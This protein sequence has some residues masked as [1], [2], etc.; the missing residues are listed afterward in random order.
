M[1]EP[2]LRARSSGDSRGKT[3]EFAHDWHQLVAVT[4]GLVTVRTRDEAWL[5]P[6][7]RAV[8]IP[9]RTKHSVEPQG[10]AR[11]QTVY[12]RPDVSQRTR[13]RCVVLQVAPLLE[14][15]IDHVVG[16]ET[17]AAD[18]P[19]SRRLVGVLLDQIA[20]AREL[21]LRLPVP[22]HPRARRVAELLTADPSDT[23]SL[24][25]LARELSTSTRTLARLFVGDT[26]LTLGQW[27]RQFRLTHALTLMASGSP[28]K[29]VA[30]EVGYESASAFVVA[31]K[32]AL[33][34]TPGKLFRGLAPLHQERRRFRTRG[35]N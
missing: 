16:L 30:I 31:F 27:R 35:G 4:G 29:D 12:L 33:G 24:V 7:L 32:H 8:W 14:A 28:V 5:V 13:S 22:K 3:P 23:P 25:A 19:P 11:L 34:T 9:A 15:L 10:R 21:P 6:T 20:N 17:L 26:G 2:I 1:S 18:D